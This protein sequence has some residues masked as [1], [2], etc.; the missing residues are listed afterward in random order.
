MQRFSLGLDFGTESLRALLV[1][2][3]TGEEIATSLY[4]YRHGVI[5]KRLPGT[6]I[7]LPENCA[8]Q[9]PNDYLDGLKN[10][11]PELIKKAKVKPEQIIGIGVDFTSC[12]MLPVK[13]DGTPLCMIKKC[14]R[15][16]HSWV[17]LWKHHASNPQAE[18][19]TKVAQKHKY[20]FLK[21]Y[22]NK[23]SAEWLFPKILEIYI[24][25]PQIYHAT[26]KFLEAGDWIVWQLT[27][28]QKRSACQAGY[29]AL[30]SK[31]DG[32]PSKSFFAEF[33]KDFEDIVDTKLIKHIYPLG[34]RAGGLTN[35]M[36]KLLGLKPGT[37]VAVAVI[38]AH[39]AVPGTSVC[40]PEKMVLVLGT[41]AC[42]MLLSK[43]LK[44][45]NGVVGVVK[46]GIIPGYYGYEAGQ[47]AVG[48]IF[49]WFVNNCVPYHYYAQAKKEKMDIYAFLEQKARDVKSDLVALDWWNGNRS[50]LM[51]ADLSGVIIGL[52][53][54]TTPEKI[55]R[56]LLEATAFGTRKIIETFEKE[57][58][59]IKEIYACGGLAVKNKLLMQIFADV[60][61]RE[62]KIAK[63]KEATALGSAIW[64]AVAAGRQMG[65]YDS[66]SEA[67]KKMAHIKKESF[68]PSKQNTYRYQKLYR[69][70]QTLHDHF[71]KNCTRIMK[72]LKKEVI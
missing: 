36:A 25:A 59:L 43:K 13:S 44:F 11:I 55:Y 30:W 35:K 45:I 56:T 50:V 42:H 12:T 53:I 10:T 3:K 41:S 58:F 8:L 66:P 32:Y 38:D 33:G 15:N 24:H 28:E 62:I 67:V 40:E 14:S 64:G 54:A 39:S 7:N 23:I 29:K 60:T 68:K 21:Y 47:A 63:S 61:G 72:E 27:G 16:P 49:T 52:T 71:G 69:I 4:H 65:G 51:D 26:D 17:K 22:S 20:P 57:G 37:P 31:K 18:L 70:Y 34:T 9:D 1:D 5:D 2:I 46:D 6:K 19:M 48:D